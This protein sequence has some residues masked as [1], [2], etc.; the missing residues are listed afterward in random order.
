MAGGR[1]KDRIVPHGWR[2][3]FSTLMNERAAL[4]ERDGDR[5]VID[6]ILAHMPNGVS[7][8][9]WAYNRAC[10]FKPKAALLQAWSDM[11][12]QDLRSPETLAAVHREEGR[13]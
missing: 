8:S 2:F 7:A 13:R 4:L 1:Y 12:S 6:M 11:I 3:A 10:Y 5:L 9:E